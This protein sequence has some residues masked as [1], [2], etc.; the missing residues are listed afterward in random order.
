MIDNT[1][2][3]LYQKEEYCCDNNEVIIPAYT[4]EDI[5]MLTYNGEPTT[6]PSEAVHIT[7]GSYVGIEVLEAMDKFHDYPIDEIWYLKNSHN[8]IIVFTLWTDDYHGI[9]AVIEEEKEEG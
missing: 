6:D 3:I 2:M 7:I 4:E 1:V 5:S 8:R 9:W